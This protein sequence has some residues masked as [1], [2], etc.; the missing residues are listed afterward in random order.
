[1][2]LASWASICE[3]QV[4]RL[5]LLRASLMRRGAKDRAV[6]RLNGHGLAAAAGALFR[7]GTAEMIMMIT[8]FANRV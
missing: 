4:R 6:R 2:S 7:A 8:V 5:A 3:V 1:M